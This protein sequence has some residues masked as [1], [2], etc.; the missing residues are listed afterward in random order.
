MNP[1]KATQTLEQAIL[2]TPTGRRI[3]RIIQPFKT[4][5]QHVYSPHYPPYISYATSWE[6]LSKNQGI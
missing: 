2:K 1:C 4:Q 3:K 5:H 6:I